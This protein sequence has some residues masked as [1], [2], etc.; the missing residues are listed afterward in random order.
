MRPVSRQG[1]GKHVPAATVTHTTGGNGCCPCQEDL[2]KRT[3]AASE[4]SSAR[5]AEERWQLCLKVVSC[6]LRAVKLKVFAR[7]R[8][9]K[10]LTGAVVI[11][12]V[13]RSTIAL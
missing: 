8:L 3:G 11:C 10:Y 12:E 2:K 7:E 4:L 1:L 5:E 13:W 9:E 6:Q